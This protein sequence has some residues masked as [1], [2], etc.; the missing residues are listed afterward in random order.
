M[1]TILLVVLM[2]MF[3]CMYGLITINSSQTWSGVLTFSDDV[4]ITGLNVV[5]TINPGTTIE[6]A[7]GHK[8]FIDRSQIIANGTMSNTINFK[9]CSTQSDFWGGVRLNR[10]NNSSFSYCTFSDTADNLLNI[11]KSVSINFN[12][13]LFQSEEGLFRSSEGLNV[14]DTCALSFVNCKFNML[15]K[16]AL[17]IARCSN[18]SISNCIFE[19]NERVEADDIFF[20]DIEPNGAILCGAGINVYSISTV[21]VLNCDFEDNWFNLIAYANY[22]K[23]GGSAICCYRSKDVT[24]SGGYFTRNN[25]QYYVEEGAPDKSAQKS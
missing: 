11:T 18:I 25:G 20:D 7:D 23:M 19:N 9:K 16:G 4:L 8:L 24:I 14:E 1:R 21:D 10:A 15:K 12:N 6:F 17:D 13:C 2:G 5:V 3:S 22:Y